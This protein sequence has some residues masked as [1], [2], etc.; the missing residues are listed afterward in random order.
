MG[1]PVAV[2]EASGGAID[3]GVN[4]AVSDDIGTPAVGDEL[5]VAN[6]I[7]GVPVALADGVGVPVEGAPMEGVLETV[8]ATK[9]LEDVLSVA[10]GV[11]LC[12]AL[13]VGVSVAAFPA[14]LPVG[15]LVIEPAGEPNG[16]PAV[17]LTVQLVVCELVSVALGEDDAAAPALNVDV[18]VG[19]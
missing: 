16:E 9:T 12:V 18:G 4:D 15:E 19:V 13:G 1:E 2:S 14:G 3:D 17:A 10:L 11:T 6:P 8:A 7:V 5:G